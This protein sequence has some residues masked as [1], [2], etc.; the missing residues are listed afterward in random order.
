ML[1][2]TMTASSAARRSLAPP[3][4][5]APEDHACPPAAAGPALSAA[6]WT[7]IV[8]AGTVLVA[9]IGWLDYVT[10]PEVGLSLAYLVPVVLAGW[11]AGRRAGVLLALAAATA[12]FSADAALHRAN[13]LPVSVWNGVTRL[14]IYAAI[15]LLAARVRRDRLQLIDLNARLARALEAERTLARTDALTGLA[16]SRAFLET[17]RTETARSRR[18]RTP[19]CV[20]YIDLDN[21]KRINDRH[22]HAAGDAFLRQVADELRRAVRDG[23]VVARIGGDEF[24][25]LLWQAEPAPAEEV[26]RRIVTRV[27]AAAAAP[28][29]KADVGASVGLAWFAVA[30]DDDEEIL[31]LADEAMFEAKQAGKHAVVLRTGS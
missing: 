24:A 14:A 15:G 18:A 28:Y 16:N 20:A 7:A 6:R 17:L 31:R 2:R 29:P 4:G 27:A 1:L 3:T 21:F 26:G 11:L 23:D 10:G 19:V 5:P 30:P 22:G 8:A 9:A 25:V 12:W 13:Y